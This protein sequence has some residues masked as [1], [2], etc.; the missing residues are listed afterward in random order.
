MNTNYKSML[1]A[2][3]GMLTL[4]T[5]CRADVFSRDGTVTVVLSYADFGN[6][7]FS[8]KISNQPSQCVG[9]WLSPSQPGFKT[10]V[11]WL[12]QARATGE[13][14]RVAADTAQLWPGSGD[15]WCKVNYVGT[16][17]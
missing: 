8:F 4:A 3:V 7:D 12:L 13:V 11:A 5:V 1:I 17:Y 14:I 10:A 15:A 16:P 9:Y 6:G 2:M